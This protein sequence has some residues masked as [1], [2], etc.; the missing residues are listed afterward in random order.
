MLG[1]LRQGGGYFLLEEFR[2][3]LSCEWGE[4]PRRNKTGSLQAR[5]DLLHPARGSLSEGGRAGLS[6]GPEDPAGKTELRTNK[7]K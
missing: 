7:R 3:L 1:W 5:L 6:Q 4:D 2:N